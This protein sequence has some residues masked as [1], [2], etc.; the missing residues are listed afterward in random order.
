MK[1]EGHKQSGLVRVVKVWA[2]IKKEKF[3]I[4]MITI[5]GLLLNTTYNIGQRIDGTN[6]RMDGISQRIDSISPSISPR[7]DATIISVNQSISE[8][9]QRIDYAIIRADKSYKEIAETKKEIE[10]RFTAMVDRL[11]TIEAGI[12]SLQPRDDSL[13]EDK[14]PTKIT[15]YQ[16]GE[17]PTETSPYQEGES[18][19]QT[20]PYQSP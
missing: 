16:E 11:T 8:I 9:N 18:G 19:P 2:W 13:K 7:I 6:L 1:N 20:S 3:I 12:S 14:P 4:I 17:P 10:L 5:L 15:P